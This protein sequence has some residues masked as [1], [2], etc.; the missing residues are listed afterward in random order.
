MLKLTAPVQLLKTKLMQIGVLL[1]AVG[2]ISSFYLT[3]N[4]FAGGGHKDNGKN[5]N[6]IS[7]KNC[8]K[9]YDAFL[10]IRHANIHGDGLPRSEEK[11]AVQLASYFNHQGCE[12]FDQFE[13]G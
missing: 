12:K 11:E 10:I 13:I 1:L 9:I 3:P 6:K 8:D 7:E 4:V 2:L 5:K